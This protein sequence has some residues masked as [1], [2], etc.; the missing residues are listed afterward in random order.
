MSERIIKV[1]ELIRDLVAQ[2]ISTTLTL[3][4]GLLL[5]VVRAEVSRDLRQARVYVS[6]FPESDEA[7]ALKTLAKERVTLEHFVHG[8][9]S[10][11]PLPRLRFFID[12]TAQ[13]N[14]VIEKILISLKEEGSDV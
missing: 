2:A 9:L 7:Y 11:K 3:K 10:M 12:K 5:T 8:K 13:K 14:D 1:N 4:E 6:A